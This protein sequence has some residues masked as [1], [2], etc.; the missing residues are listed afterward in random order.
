MM[1]EY[2]YSY[3]VHFSNAD[4]LIVDTHIRLRFLDQT[5]NDFLYTLLVLSVCLSLYFSHCFNLCMISSKICLRKAI[6][7]ITLVGV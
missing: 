2:Y 5:F 3:F 4:R 7:K 1:N 6:L